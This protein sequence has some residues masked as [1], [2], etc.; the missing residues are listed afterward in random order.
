MA[1]LPWLQA[2]VTAGGDPGA[3]AFRPEILGGVAL[4]D[5]LGPQLLLLGPAALGASATDVLNVATFATQALWA[6]LGQR[7]LGDLS[8]LLGRGRPRPWWLVGAS[9][10]FLAFAPFVGWRVG[11][12]HLTLLVGLLPFLSVLAL[13]TASAAASL[14]RC[15]IAVAA[16]TVAV[17]LPFVGQQI[18][19]YGALL[20]APLLAAVLAT[21]GRGPRSLVVPG[22][23]A[24]AGLLLAAPGLIPMLRHA[25]SSDAL[26]ELGGETVTYSYLT[27]GP[28]DWLTSL[29]WLPPE[30]GAR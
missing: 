8:V 12:G 26:R 7:V 18:V 21:G 3:W 17:S 15:L 29:L 9:L 28:R 30:A 20:G 24:L 19:L 1:L 10:V 25:L 22:L 14:N 4:R 13:V 27:A 6:F 16:L 23:A 11:Y 5:T 2:L